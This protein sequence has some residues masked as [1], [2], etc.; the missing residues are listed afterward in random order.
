[1]TNVSKGD[2]I[3]EEETTQTDEI[4]QRHEAVVAN[5]GNSNCCSLLNIVTI[6]DNTVA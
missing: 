2:E 3:N 4:Q 5:A 1:M 6:P